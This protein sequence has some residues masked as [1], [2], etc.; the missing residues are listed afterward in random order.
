STCEHCHEQMPAL[1]EIYE[2][3][4][5]KGYGLIGI[6]LDADIEEFTG[7]SNEKGMTWP[8]FSELI[9]WGSPAAKAFNVKATPS[10]ILLDQK[11][12]IL[13]KPVDHRELKLEL[14]KF[15]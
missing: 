3:L 12:T 8:V 7:T 11:G 2:D 4:K 10:F 14:E 15:F 1:D 13:A 5:E 9:G 6:A